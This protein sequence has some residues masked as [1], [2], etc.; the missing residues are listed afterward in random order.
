MTHVFST[1]VGFVG[2]RPVSKGRTRCC[3]RTFHAVAAVR[4]TPAG[5]IRALQ[6]GGVSLNQ[7]WCAVA[8]KARG[9]RPG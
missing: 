8:D 4:R 9:L 6:C 2:I 5:R 3:W 1:A 7:L